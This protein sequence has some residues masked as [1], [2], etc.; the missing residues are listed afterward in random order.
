MNEKNPITRRHFLQTSL[1]TTGTLLASNVTD[2]KARE[3]SI[4]PIESRPNLVLNAKDLPSFREKL[5]RQ[6]FKRILDIYTNSGKTDNTEAL[7]LLALTTNE[8]NYK[9]LAA[10]S[11]MKN[12]RQ[13]QKIG[14]SIL[15]GEIAPGHQ[16]RPGANYPR[17]DFSNIR[18]IHRLTNQYD[19]IASFKTLSADEEREFQNVMFALVGK[20]MS[21]EIRKLNSNYSDR[22]HNFHSDNITA[23]GTVALCFP[24]H[25]EAKNWL[26]YALT[27][28]EWQMEN[29]V[30]DGAWHESPRYH[31]AILRSLIPFLYAVKRNTGKNLFQN[32]NFRAM[33]DWLVRIQTPRNKVLG[34]WLKSG[35]ENYAI[36][37][38]L[39]ANPTAEA[40]A[41]LPALG[42]SDWANF[43]FATLGM[44]APMYQPTD[45][46][47]AGRLMWAWERAGAPVA[48]ESNLLMLPLFLTDPTIK[49]IPQ[50]LESEVQKNIGYA[51]LRS[52]YDQPSEK[53]LIFTAGKRRDEHWA[54]H[55]HR[56]QNSFSIFAEGIPLALDSAS[57][58]Y[59]TSDQALWHK[60]T[61]AH[62][63]VQFA[64]RD[65]EREDAEIIQFESQTGADY[66]V[67]DATRAAGEVHHVL[68][69]NRHILF[70]KPDYY[71]IW[72]YIRSYIDGDWILHSPAQE[73]KRS[74]HSLEFVTPWNVSLDTHFVLPDTLTEIQ[75]G[76]GR[77]GHW[78]KPDEKTA[79][80][81][82][83][84]KYIKVK[85]AAGKDFLT[86]LHPR[87]S[88]AEKLTVQKIGDAENFLEI[89]TATQT[90]YIMLFPIAQ[91]FQDEARKISFK[92]RVA[93]IRSGA[94][95]ELILLDGESLTFNEKTIE[96]KKK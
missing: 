94:K 33:L 4:Q 35:K 57:G 93:V 71:V 77:I 66:L 38:G 50:N 22:R 16:P 28:F 9:Q 67:G 82:T 75:T 54:G 25:K 85:N 51:I 7:I 10:Q 95:N 6:P 1:L 79:P 20:L 18:F 61:V 32:K 24:D 3:I 70:V 46:N 58:P 60:A 81:F 64:G 65:Q 26:E 56:D 19:V 91:N 27:D 84:Q 45:P 15:N 59:G 44:A 2:I 73:I 92:G 47:F 86:V 72:D 62:N 68:Q 90:D 14:T 30:L 36:N 88:D 52:D 41:E 31:G 76:E 29:G 40:V 53:Y 42:D 80:P 87:K 49:S 21:P 8:Q 34:A 39:M 37:S 74:E 43:W 17:Y 55:F 12:L 63:L 5:A 78:R 11:L 89:K 96:G 83:M 69:W 13:S 23:I 48:P